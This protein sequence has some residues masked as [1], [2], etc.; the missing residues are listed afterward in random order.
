MKKKIKKRLGSI[1]TPYD[2]EGQDDEFL[3]LLKEFE[4]KEKKRHRNNPVTTVE[5]IEAK[6]LNCKRITNHHLIPVGN[7]YTDT[8]CTVCKGTE[9]GKR[10]V[11]AIG[12]FGCGKYCRIKQGEGYRGL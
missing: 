4:A 3:A 7:L 12:H 6:C 10:W 2:D 11:Q 1:E 9:T 8:I 5:V